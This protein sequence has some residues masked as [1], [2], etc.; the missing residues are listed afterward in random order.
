MYCG[1]RPTCHTHHQDPTQ[2]PH[3]QDMTIHVQVVMNDSHCHVP[4]S[5][6]SPFACYACHANHGQKGF[7]C[8]HTRHRKEVDCHT[9]KTHLLKR[10][11]SMEICTQLLLTQ[12]QY[13]SNLIPPA[14]RSAPPVHLS[15]RLC[16]IKNGPRNVPS[17]G[18][19]WGGG[20]SGIFV[21]VANSLA[22]SSFRSPKF[23]T[24]DIDN[25]NIHGRNQLH[26][27]HH[28][29]AGWLHQWGRRAN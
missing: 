27:L 6:P 18:S 8:S 12:L 9:E 24:H 2:S 28:G 11:S 5:S 23:R 13:S 4:L 14:T 25:D 10:C 15:H 7:S 19:I 3:H 22:L 1:L 16:S 21:S 20:G 17:S 29:C 26:G